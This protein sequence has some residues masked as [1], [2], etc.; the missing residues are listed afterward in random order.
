MRPSSSRFAEA[1]RR[2]HRIATEV[3]VLTEGE[4]RKTITTAVGGSVTLDAKAQTRG[5]LDLQLTEDVADS[6]IPTRATDLLAP[7]GNELR[8]SRGIQFPD[9]TRELIRLGVYRIESPRPRSSAQGLELHVAGYDRSK[10]ISDARFEAPFQIE[11][12]EN[13][14]DAILR[15]LQDAWPEMPYSFA[16]TTLTTP[17]LFAEEQGDRWAFAQEMATSIGMSL[18][19]DGDGV[20]QLRPAGSSSSSP[21][22]RLT[23][24][25]GGVLLEAE[26]DWTREGTYNRVIATGE[27]TGE[28]AP[29]RGVAT[30]DNP[31][32]PTYYYGPFGK[33]PRFYVSQFIT[34][35]AQALDAAHAIL[36]S[37]LGTTQQVSFGALVDPRLEPDDVVQ[38]TRDALEL[39]EIHV[40]DSLTIPLDVAGAMTGRTRAVVVSG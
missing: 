15:V 12:G 23:E 33:V 18:Y 8:V 26:R 20:C 30:D 1:I 6:L 39:D 36:N 11:Q 4:V 31:L 9:G 5:R 19:F 37:E 2:S 29:A 7:Y 13:Y 14:A 17:Q 38:I 40:I 28:D 16:S 10:R 24:G 34:T 3:E 25:E 22:V 27:N 35:D 32:S 21:V